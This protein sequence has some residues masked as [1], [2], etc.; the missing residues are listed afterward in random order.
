[1]KNNILLIVFL[2]LLGSCL[3]NNDP[4]FKI[5]LVENN[6]QLETS[7]KMLERKYV[8]RHYLGKTIDNTCVIF[9]YQKFS[10]V[11]N[12]AYLP[13][14]EFYKD[15]LDD[16]ELDQ[17]IISII[18]NKS[19]TITTSSI[20]NNINKNKP[21]L[22][23]KKTFLNMNTYIPISS[24]VFYQEILYRIG[25]MINKELK[26]NFSNYILSSIPLK[27]LMTLDKDGYLSVQNIESA[28][29][30]LYIKD[31]SL[32]LSIEEDEFTFIK[33]KNIDM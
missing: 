3:F 15:S 4:T 12:I 5:L 24:P 31:N 2:L 26:Y 29:N 9:L 8:L 19:D 10:N 20:F 21:D 14:N 25:I 7:T 27:E 18:K 22:L 6:K 32:F 28:L 23:L 30:A 13:N 16:T 11:S 17:Y 33:E 1:M